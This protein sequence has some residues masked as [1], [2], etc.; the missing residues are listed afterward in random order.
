MGVTEAFVVIYGPVWVNN[1]SPKSMTTTWLGLLNSCSI[2]GMILG[3]LIA[4]IIINFLKGI[5]SW[6]FTLE[7]Q[8]I[9]LIPISIFFFTEHK[10]YIDLDLEIEEGYINNMTNKPNRNPFLSDLNRGRNPNDLFSF[11]R[12]DMVYNP[13]SEELSRRMPDI[14]EDSFVR[15]SGC[16]KFILQAKYVI[17]NSVYLSVIC[18]LCSIYFIVTGIQF[19]MTAYLIEVIEG[20]P[21]HVVIIFSFT[22]VTAPL[23]GVL[24][25][26]TISDKFGGY[27]G[28]NSIKAIKM[29]AAFGFISFVFSF[30]LCF[31]FSFFYITVLLWA[32]LFFGAAIV[33]IATGISI[34]AVRK[35]CQVTS[36]SLSQLFFNLFG[37]FLSPILTGFIM[38]CFNDKREGFI[39]GMRVNYSWSLIAMLSL[40]TGIFFTAKANNVTILGENPNSN[41]T[42]SPNE[43]ENDL[44]MFVRQEILRRMVMSAR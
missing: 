18:A 2:F 3:Y 43:M 28:K 12:R 24:I 44:V 14:L 40:V 10:E 5:I 25:G 38:D 33:P 1:Y 35:E 27:K 26:G 30:P 42:D 34:S 8:G 32:F 17:T 7:I 37:F 4:G 11:A 29:C 21:V 9:A 13:N 19:W 22:T 16:Q 15:I 31:I 41:D 39:W 20:D 36:S 6:R 23:S